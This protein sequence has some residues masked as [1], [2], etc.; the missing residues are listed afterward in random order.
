MRAC[1][2]IIIT[3]DEGMRLQFRNSARWVCDPDEMMK[4]DGGGSPSIGSIAAVVTFGGLAVA[5]GVFTT[6]GR[7]VVGIGAVFLVLVTGIGFA[8]NRRIA[9]KFPP[10]TFHREA[11]AGATE[12]IESAGSRLAAGDSA[13][14]VIR[15]IVA[16]SGEAEGQIWLFAA[17]DG[18][19][20]RVAI[21]LALPDSHGDPSPPPALV[22]LLHEGWELQSSQPQEWVILTRS[23]RIDTAAMLIVVVESLATLFDVPAGSEWS[24]QAFA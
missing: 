3:N 2:R 23:Q 8:V 7:V 13:A 4:R 14:F 5:L 17:E 22:H 24:C 19:V 6:V 16:N 10:V 15:P 21:E 12:M 18:V 11:P 1:R 9:R 20:E